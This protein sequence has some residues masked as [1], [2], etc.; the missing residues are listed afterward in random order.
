LSS[1]FYLYKQSVRV[2][3]TQFWTRRTHPPPANRILFDPVVNHGR[4]LEYPK[5]TRKKKD[6]QQMSQQRDPS[7]RSHNVESH[8][9]A[10]PRGGHRARRQKK[11]C[12]RNAA[13][14]HNNG[15]GDISKRFSIIA[16]RGNDV[17][18]TLSLFMNI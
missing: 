2:C 14:Q 7:A 15:N 3:Q 18:R 17:A 12:A 13:T 11:K 5:T 9:Y 4:L 6:V 1:R 10:N 16:T 8:P